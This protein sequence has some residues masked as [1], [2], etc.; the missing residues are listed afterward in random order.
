[1]EIYRF[2]RG[3]SPLVVSMPHIG[4]HV[5]DDI[6]A[7]LTDEALQLPDTDWHLDR[8]YDFLQE[9][10]ATVLM[11]THSRFVID[12]NRP[13]DDANLYPGQDTTGLVPIDMGDRAR[14]YR[15]APPDDLEVDARR[16][17]FWKPYHDKLAATLEEVRGAHG[18]ALLWD[19]HSIK[20]VLPR[21]FAGQLPDLNLGTADGGSCGAGLGERLLAVAAAAPAYSSVLNGRYK[22]GY[23]TRRYGRPGE[24]IHAVQL[25]LSWRTYM[26]ETHPF[27]F[28]D[29][30]AA[31]VRPTLRRMLEAM[32]DWGR[33][34]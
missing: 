4:T 3:A 22:G 13:P 8:L 29:D 10:N 11:A 15:G 6:A 32:L 27:A 2:H 20:S 9:L 26:N 12:L 31:G 28:R 34:L 5:P 23:I 30:L 33:A 7:R 21:F 24:R 19:A 1:M 16:A 14:I 17:A 25:E 18:F